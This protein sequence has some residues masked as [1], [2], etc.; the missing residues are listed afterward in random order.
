VQAVNV[1]EPGCSAGVNTKY[2]QD[3]NEGKD[4]DRIL[5][6]D[7]IVTKISQTVIYLTGAISVI[8]IVIGGLKYVLSA[9]DSAG[10]QSAKNTI[11]Y[12]IVGLVVTL[13]AQSIVSFVL[14]KL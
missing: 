8:M 1:L 7:G 12:A 13:F 3:V 9:G 10:V 5:G 14:S 4:S 6:P 2:C 11:L